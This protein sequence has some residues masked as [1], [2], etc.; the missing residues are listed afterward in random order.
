MHES[1]IR[2]PSCIL[3]EMRITGP[4]AF[5]VY[6]FG[7]STTSHVAVSSSIVTNDMSLCF[8]V[9]TTLRQTGVPMILPL[10]CVCK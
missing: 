10:P 2:E 9:R 7:N 8:F 6:S 4:M 5:F 3:P 1:A